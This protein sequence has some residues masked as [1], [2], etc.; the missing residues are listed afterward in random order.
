MSKIKVKTKKDHR[1]GKPCQSSVG[2]ISFDENGVAEIEGKDYLAWK[3][4]M[5]DLEKVEESSPSKKPEDDLGKS[6]P[7]GGKGKGKKKPEDDI[8]ELPEEDLNAMAMMV[9]G[10]TEESL[11]KM[12]REEKVEYI[13]SNMSK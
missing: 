9:E 8:D 5:P 4:V 13:R 1:W 2:T 7:K 10:A 12:S 3:G 6:D 11:S